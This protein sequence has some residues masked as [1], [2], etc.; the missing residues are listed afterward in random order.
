M[1]LIYA[2]PLV[3][4]HTPILILQESRKFMK[5]EYLIKQI[6]GNDYR[7]ELGNLLGG[8]SACSFIS[9]DI[10]FPEKCARA[11]ALKFNQ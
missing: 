10:D 6:D 5:V 3:A 2:K 8:E 7:N 4:C 11:S 1:A 9:T